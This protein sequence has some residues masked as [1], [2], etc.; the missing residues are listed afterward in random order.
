[1]SNC[2]LCE[3]LTKVV[4]M[5][6]LAVV[7]GPAFGAEQRF[8]GV[9][10]GKRSLTKG[11]ASPTCPAEEDVS[12]TI[13]GET[14]TFT[15]SALKEFTMPFYPGQDGSFGETY[16]GEGGTTV[17]Y[18]GRVIG[19]VIDADVTNPTCEHHWHLKKAS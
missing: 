17:H 2:T 5:V 11:P 6:C 19:D 16:T 1:V 4:V 3:I 15:N 10:S 7:V 13:H 8:D 12:A 18:S 9:Y 14:L